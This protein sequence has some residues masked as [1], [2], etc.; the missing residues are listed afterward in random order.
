MKYI[1]AVLIIYASLYESKGQS[2]PH[3]TVR[4]VYGDYQVGDTFIRHI[5]VSFQMPPTC[6]QLTEI[7]TAKSYSVSGDSLIY[8]FQVHELEG[9]VGSNYPNCL[10]HPSNIQ[11]DYTRT[12]VYEE[13]DSSVIYSN[14]YWK[15]F[16]SS[17][18]LRCP[19][20]IFYDNKF[21]S[22]K[23][24]QCHIDAGNAIVDID[25][26]EGLGLSFFRM[27][28]EA[29]ITTETLIYYHK[30]NEQPW[31]DGTAIINSIPDLPFQKISLYPTLVKDQFTVNLQGEVAAKQASLMLYDGLGRPVI[32]KVLTE[33]KTMFDS[34]GLGKGF[35][36]WAIVYQ[37]RHMKNGKLIIQ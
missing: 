24:N 37:G 5:D 23:N 9:N 26:I 19:D 16:C 28:A 22:K 27:Y 36:T 17:D 6:K 8:Q 12:T 33:D 35:Y 21:G 3:S 15:L 18:S 2:L 32:N 7:V 31:S 13:L 25:Q 10:Y 20:S 14:E 4:E 29:K 34:G 30:L 11:R 1:F